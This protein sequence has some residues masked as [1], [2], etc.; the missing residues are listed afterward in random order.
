MPMEEGDVC[1]AHLRSKL[2]ACLD[3]NCH[4][5][6]ENKALRQEILHL[7]GQITKLQAQDADKSMIW[8]K[9]QNHINKNSPS[10]EKQLVQIDNVEEGLGVDNSLTRREIFCSAIKARSPRV[11]RPPPRPTTCL[12]LAP[13]LTGKESQ[14][15][16]PLMPPPPPPLPSNLQRRSSNSL[17]K[18]PEVAESKLPPS[19][20]PP[21]PL[22]SKLQVRASSS[23]R[24][25]PEVV[26][27]YHSITR[28]DGKPETKTGIAGTQVTSNARE[29]I[30]EIEN[31]SAYLLAIKSDVETQGEFISFLIKEVQNATYTE[32]SDVEAFVKWLDEELSYLVDERA[33][34]KHFPQWPEQKADAMREAAFGYRDLKNLESEVSSFSD[35]LRQPTGVALKR[36]R[37]LQ[38]KLECSVHNLER[39]RDS[40]SK[41]Y[42]EFQIPWEWM[43][44]TGIIAQLKSGSMRLAKKYM[45]RVITALQSYASSEDEELMLQG[46]RFAFRVHQ[47]VGGFDEESRNAF[48]ELRK[49]ASSIYS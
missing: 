20:P 44:D 28:R 11:P 42:K 7:K 1:F 33:V 3:R 26:E 24:R 8:K 15:P 49:L 43:L 12:Q 17:R 36:I 22:P 29:M 45:N 13:K 38:E 6:K 2:Q 18:V 47:F 4:L 31:R 41:R 9:Q 19:P 14:L 16:S 10:Q 32:I 48:Q 39:V 25:A 40:A 34:L 30:G 23:V 21:P 5:E 35:D 27:F 37:A 46:V